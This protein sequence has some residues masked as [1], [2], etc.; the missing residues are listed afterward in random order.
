MGMRS[1]FQSFFELATV[2]LCEI[3]GKAEPRL[4]QLYLTEQGILPKAAEQ[5]W[6]SFPRQLN[7]KVNLPP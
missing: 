3:S 2:R 7:I 5:L 1:L 4:S 6:I